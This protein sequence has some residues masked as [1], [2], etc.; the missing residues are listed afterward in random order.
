MATLK[1]ATAITIS[2]TEIAAIPL[3]FNTNVRICSARIHQP[4]KGR[5]IQPAFISIFTS[6]TCTS[7]TADTS[8]VTLVQLHIR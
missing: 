4:A 1:T 8:V 5:S 7:C 6:T 2:A 3:T